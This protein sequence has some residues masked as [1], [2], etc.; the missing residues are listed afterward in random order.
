MSRK[1]PFS[2]GQIWE[3]DG[4]KNPRGIIRFTIIG[5]ATINNPKTYK[6]CRYEYLDAY[7]NNRVGPSTQEFSHAH[8]KRYSK[9]KETN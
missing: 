9:L 6:L 8:L 2:T 3:T 1:T 5:P 7:W 4:T